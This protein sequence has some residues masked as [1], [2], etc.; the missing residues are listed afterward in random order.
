M[1]PLLL[2]R[3][4]V[5]DPAGCKDE[6]RYPLTG[7]WWLVMPKG[8]RDVLFLQMLGSHERY[9]NFDGEGILVADHAMPFM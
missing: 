1:K 8:A 2:D 5:K 3:T 6:H 4:R 9:A 7:I